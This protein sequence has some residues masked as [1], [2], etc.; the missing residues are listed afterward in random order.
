MRNDNRSG[1]PAFDTSG[2]YESGLKSLVKSL[3]WAFAIVN[4]NASLF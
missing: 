1:L 3:Q 4:E 2:R